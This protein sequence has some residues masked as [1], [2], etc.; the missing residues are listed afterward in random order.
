MEP[1]DHRV[2]PLSLLLDDCSTFPI[3]Q[4]LLD[5]VVCD[6]EMEPIIMAPHPHLLHYE[7]GPLVRY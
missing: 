3:L 7:V 2:L 4:L 5:G 1:H 6:T